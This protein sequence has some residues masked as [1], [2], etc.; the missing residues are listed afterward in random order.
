[1]KMNKK[2]LIIISIIIVA[3]IIV[4]FGGIYYVKNKAMIMM[5]NAYILMYEDTSLEDMTVLT[6]V[7]ATPTISNKIYWIVNKNGDIY[8]YP[9]N[10]EDKSDKYLKHVKTLSK[11]ELNNLKNDIDDYIKNYA[12]GR[13]DAKWD[14]EIEGEIKYVSKNIKDDI[15]SAYFSK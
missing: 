15:L 3:I 10:V 2:M 5:D 1:M 12:C 9:N 11:E 4:S 13:G 7:G 14:V 8:T 6:M